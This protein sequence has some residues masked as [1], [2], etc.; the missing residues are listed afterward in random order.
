MGI[1]IYF[2]MYFILVMSKLNF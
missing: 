1:V 2:Q